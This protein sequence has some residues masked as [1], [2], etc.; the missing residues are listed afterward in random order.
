MNHGDSEYLICAKHT[1]YSYLQH[2]TCDMCEV[3]QLRAEVKRL[4][5]S[6]DIWKRCAN[7]YMQ[8]LLQLRSHQA[9]VPAWQPIETA[10]KDGTAILARNENTG[11]TYVVGWHRG[12]ASDD[13]EDEPHWSDTPN[14]N[15]AESLY[16][17]GLYFTHWMPLPAAPGEAPQPIQPSED[18]CNHNCNQGRNCTCK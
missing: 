7:E 9:A 10:P 5:A 4:T 3:E 15:S 6:R 14:A 16:F 1:T 2:D 8:E 18:T 13:L 11:G 12:G 17:N